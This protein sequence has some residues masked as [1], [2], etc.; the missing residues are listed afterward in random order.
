MRDIPF[1]P[2]HAD[3]MHC[4]M[5]VY[6]SVLDYFL[7]KKPSWSEL[8][9][10][11]GYKPGKAAWTV[12][13]LPKMAELG[14]DIRMIEPFDYTRYLDEGDSYLRTL[15]TSEQIEWYRK[16]SNIIEMKKLIPKFQKAINHERRRASLKDIDN[17]LAEGR[18]VFVTLNS[19]TLNDKDGFV[20]HAV[21]ILDKKGDNYIA[22]DPGSPPR[23]SRKIPSDKLLKAMGGNKNTAE[24]TGFKLI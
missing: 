21:L 24:V 19:R 11:V 20:S 3:D 17:M 12:G 9:E 14:L 2:N 6:A 22:H 23:P 8:E 1:Y 5:S 15:Y 10:L 16:N 4:E 7:H 18:L 13:P